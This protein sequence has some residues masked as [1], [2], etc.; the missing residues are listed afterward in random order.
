MNVNR[1]QDYYVIDPMGMRMGVLSA[2]GFEAAT[3]ILKNSSVVKSSGV[4]YLRNR[5]TGE[6]RS[7]RVVR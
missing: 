2:Y 4:Y 7:I 1:V 6:M 3:E 5:W